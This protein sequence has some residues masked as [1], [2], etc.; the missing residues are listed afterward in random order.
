MDIDH[1]F[2]GFCQKS[3]LHIQIHV[4]IEN[5]NLGFNFYDTQI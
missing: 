3:L 1:N 4:E 2:L 5:F